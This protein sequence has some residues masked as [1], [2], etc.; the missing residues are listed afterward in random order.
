MSCDLEVNRPGWRS[1]DEVEQNIQALP[2]ASELDT[3][4]LGVMLN[5]QIISLIKYLIHN[6]ALGTPAVPFYPAFS[7]PG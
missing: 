7:S 3:K 4:F 5:M 1:D 2:F 6:T